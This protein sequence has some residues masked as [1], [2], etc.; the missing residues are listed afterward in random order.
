MEEVS[1]QQQQQPQQVDRLSEHNSRPPQPS[2]AAVKSTDPAAAI[3]DIQQAPLSPEDESAFVLFDS[4]KALVALMTPVVLAMVLTGL[5]SATLTVSDQLKSQVGFSRYLVL[6]DN[7][8]GATS[9]ERLEAAVVNALVLVGVILGVTVLMVALYFF[10]CMKLFLL[11]MCFSV[12]SLLSFTGALLWSIY[13]QNY[14]LRV[15]AITFY[16][17]LWNLGIVGVLAVFWHAPKVKGGYL[18]LVSMLMAWVVSFLPEWTTWAFMVALSMYDIC[19]VLSPCG[20]LKALIYLAQTRQE[21][22]PALVYE[23]EVPD[24]ESAPV[25]V[26]QESGANLSQ[27]LIDSKEKKDVPIEVKME[28]LMTQTRSPSPNEGSNLI[29]PTSQQTDPVAT[30]DKPV[31]PT[32]LMEEARQQP[33]GAE[34]EDDEPRTV[35]LGLGDFV[36]YSVLVARGALFGWVTMVSTLVAI[37]SGLAITLCLLAI[38]R[39]ALPALP[40]SICFGIIFYFSARFFLWPMMAQFG[41]VGVWI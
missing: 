38:L 29:S 4:M 14:Q 22:I 21:A 28:Q 34:L 37:V 35:K 7:A 1:Q 40:V 18:V 16:L 25:V 20:P 13:I 12:F 27:P 39:K 6:N 17:A 5:V 8:A 11:W 3:N 9:G 26:K 23:V 33:P 36:F 30:P 41:L 19:A 15:D 32:S 24:D 10:R 2:N 31:K